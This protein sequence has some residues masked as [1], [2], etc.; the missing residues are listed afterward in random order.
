M[1]MRYFLTAA[2]I[3][4]ALVVGAAGVAPAAHAEDTI[5]GSPDN[6]DPGIYI[7][8]A[9]GAPSTQAEIDSAN[10]ASQ[11]GVDAA[12]AKTVTGGLPPDPTGGEEF[13]KIM[14]WIVSLFAWLVGAAAVAL[15]YAMFYTV[16]TMG[17]YIKNLTAVGVTWRILRDIGNITLVFGFLAIGITTILN[18]DWYGGG[19]KMLPMLLVAAVFLNFSLFIS[20]AIIDTGNLFATQFYT[21]IKGGSLPTAESLSNTTILNAIEKDGIS[22]KIMSQLG[23]VTIYTATKDTKSNLF[24]GT[25]VWIIGF[26]SIILFLVTAFVMFSLAFILIARFVILLFLIILAPVGF[27]GFAIPKLKSTAGKW[28]DT[29]IEQTITAPV[30]L[31]CLYIALAVITDVQFLRGFGSAGVAPDWA[32]TLKNNIP[33]FASLLLSFLVAMGLL[34]AVIIISKKLSA[35]GA[36][37]ATQLAGKL[38]F[39]LTA[40][41]VNR[42]IGRGAYFASRGLRQSKGF[43]K[44]N[45]M[46]GRVLTGTLDRAAKASFDV[47]G[48]AIGGGLKGLGIEAGEVPK[49]GFAGAHA[50]NVKEH[51][52][53]AKRIETAHKDTFEETTKEREDIEKRKKELTEAEKAKTTAEGA[54]DRAQRENDAAKTNKEQH[55]AEVARLTAID[56]AD[57][58]AGRISSVGAALRAANE[59]SDGI[60][61]RFEDAAKALNKASENVKAA[62]A[63]EKKAKEAKET[64]EKAPGKRLGDE[65]TAGKRAYAEGIDHPI[66]NVLN[67][68]TLVSYGPGDSGAARKIKNSLKEKSKEEKAYELMKE[69]LEKE[70]P[71]EE[72]KEE[73]KAEEGPKTPTT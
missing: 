70:E 9:T 64:A 33:A 31:L 22:N 26:M 46:T 58:S 48:A 66:L 34:I 2:F 68:L 15:D 7:D 51:E 12:A 27:A 65:I 19:K 71:K 43:N 53:E 5:I 28:W 14:T 13:G 36:K 18:V 29:L 67:P 4:L 41:G 38:T 56:K 10:T 6:P 20:E 25:S 3:T 69:A 60:N 47:R 55:E 16:V 8:P 17:D 59:K 32:G 21:Q 61:K 49:E 37:G 63:A 24:K 73:P 44:L 42:T 23:L 57:T 45:A 11:K 35:F 50:R 1:S 54:K 39:G 72:T 40:W 62:T 52:E 30:L